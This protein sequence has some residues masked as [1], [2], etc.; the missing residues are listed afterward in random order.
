MK[1]QLR[2]LYLIISSTGSSVELKPFSERKY[3]VLL[4][5]AIKNPNMAKSFS[6]TWKKF[7]TFEKH[8]FVI[9]DTQFKKKSTKPVLK[10]TSSLRKIERFFLYK[11]IGIK[12]HLIFL[13][14]G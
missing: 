4:P 2:K 3:C 9:V 13:L 6:N 10:K 12:T 1:L 14:I 11:S 5:K 8:H 7:S